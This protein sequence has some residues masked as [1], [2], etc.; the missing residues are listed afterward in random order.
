[1]KHPSKHA[2]PC[3]AA[4]LLGAQGV[5]AQGGDAPDLAKQLSNPIANLI[6]VPFKLN[7][8]TGIGAANAERLT[9]NIQ[10]V[11]PVSVGQDTNLIIRTIV[12]I[13]HAES[14]IP[15][16]A[17]QHGLGDVL[18]SFFFSPK[19]PV[20]GW[21]VGAGP[22][23]LYPTA[24][25][26]S[27]GADK[28]SAGPTAVALKQQGGWTYGVLA[29]H[30]WSFAGAGR[31]D[32]SATF[33]Q[34]FGSYTTAHGMTFSVN[35]ESTYDWNSTRW[36]VPLNLSVSQL[37]RLGSQP[38]SFA[39][40]YRNYLQTPAGGPDWGLTFTVTFLFPK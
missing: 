25:R 3:A 9:L 27:L 5:H 13:I 34:P 17:D 23:V 32:V 35:T 18:Q 29:N 4:F 2:W 39:A 8:D 14:P 31:E 19:K 22:A 30:L 10:P 15:G 20:G 28:W 12:P 37:V 6:S 26:A 38:V 40:G 1:M 7:W 21:I 24:T 11:V 36:T 16:G 33:V